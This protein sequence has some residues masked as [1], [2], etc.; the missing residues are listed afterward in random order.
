MS[1]TTIYRLAKE[2]NWKVGRKTTELKPKR[3]RPE[4]Y[5]NEYLSQ[6]TALCMLGCTNEQ[7]ANFFNVV[8]ETIYEWKRTKSDFSEALRAGREKGS[9]KVAV[10]LFQRCIGYNYQEEKTSYEND[11]E[12]SKV[13]TKKHSPPEIKAIA[14]W[15]KNKHPDLWRDKQE[16]EHT[17]KTIRIGLPPL[18]RCKNVEEFNKL[19]DSTDSDS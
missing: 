1:R 6:A 12:V 16:I 17:D 11:T 5:K 10:S 19:V 15:L 14:L 13:V 8:E 18:K 4:K 7:L 9:A 3:G 2:H